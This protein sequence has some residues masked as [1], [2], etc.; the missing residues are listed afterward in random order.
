MPSPSN[1]D[2]EEGVVVSIVSCDA[3]VEKEVVVV[4]AGGGRDGI[5]ERT[6]EGDVES[7]VT[8]DDEPAEEG[9]V[10]NG[11]AGICTVKSLSQP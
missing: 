2:V 11:R 8:V 5:G 4:T 1:R 3:R 9:G 7:M 10:A 6:T